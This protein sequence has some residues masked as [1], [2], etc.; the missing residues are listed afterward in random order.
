MIDERMKTTLP[1]CLR[2]DSHAL[3]SPISEKAPKRDVYHT[4]TFSEC[5]DA[6]VDHGLSIG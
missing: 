2:A 6:F 3:P 4:K 5:F 1:G